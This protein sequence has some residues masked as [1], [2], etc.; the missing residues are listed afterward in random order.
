VLP[1]SRRKRLARDLRIALLLSVAAPTPAIASEDG[2]DTIVVTARRQDER[3]VDVPLAISVIDTQ[4]LGAGEVDSLQTLAARVPGLN[5]E[6][7]W[8]G[9]NSFP[10]L[11]GQN[12]PSV[13]GDNVGM[14]VDGVYQG[15]RD[16]IDVE[17]LD[18]E[19]IEVI[20]GPQSALF[21]R[22]SFAGL[23][24]Y[25]PARPTEHLLVSGSADLGSDRL[26]GLNA[27]ASGPI[28]ARFKAR[29][30]VSWKQASGTF[31]DT[32]PPDQNLGGSRRF[33]LVGSIATRE[34][35]GPLSLRLSGRYGDVRSDQPAFFTLDHRQFNCGGRD[36]ASGVWSYFC[37]E[38]PVESPSALSPDVP[39]SRTRTGQLALHLSLDLGGAELRSLSS[40][41]HADSDAFRDFDGGAP[42]DTYGVCLQGVNC[43]GVG[44]LSIPVVR[45]QMVNIV[46]RRSL[47]SRE[48]SQELRL[49][50]APGRRFGWQLGAALS[51]SRLRTVSAYG[52]ER[53][54]LEGAEHL[55]SLVLSNPQ[56]V[57]A[58]A[59]INNALTVDPAAAQTVQN[60]FIS[61][62][63]IIALFATGDYR[64][65]DT[66]RLRGEARTSWERAGID[67]RRSNFQPSFGSSLGS[68]NF[69][70]ITPRF[71]LD[72]RPA[73]G[74]LLYASYAR[75]SR[76]GG[77]NTTL[78]LAP[79]ERTFAPETNWT[80]E[81]GVHYSGTGL[82]RGAQLTLYDIDWRNTQ[83]LGFSTTPG[84][85]ALITRN[86]R[87]IRTQGAEVSVRIAPARWLEFDMA[88]SYTDPR[89]KP[90]SEDPG[91]GAFCGLSA[92]SQTS[93]FC[94]IRPSTISPGQLVPDISGKLVL[95][96]AQ[97][98]WV[99]GV[100]FAPQAQMLR[101]AKLRIGLNYLDDVYERA[102]NGLYYGERTLLD[103]RLTLP[104]GMFSLD[105]WGTNLTGERYIRA[106]AGRQPQFYNGLPRPTDL[107]LGEGRRV[108]LTLRFE[109]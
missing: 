46:Q 102:V 53:G 34:G 30:A 107:I 58:P 82:V 18:L 84:V 78:G 39:E 10:I 41:Y 106:A 8:G 13:A 88:G 52:G 57:G 54:S 77:I 31:G 70:D 19:R 48:L 90:G 100:T 15:N 14:F 93:S 109:D 96:A 1:S 16:A 81:I 83:I 24:H 9:A 21:G 49:L 65:T 17:P 47:S 32:E 95:R 63:R 35:S 42:G 7:I 108:G 75:G 22:S 80:T 67:S 4:S 26:F 74:W 23:I 43:T 6:A 104:L 92:S 64:L 94:T 79:E 61:R 51:W 56:R 40:V 44:S 38:A 66:L 71:S 76:S 20:H 69:Y 59:A 11:R 60:D 103:A 68:R 91:S 28:D 85:T 27:I 36:P 72:W 97:L 73:G 25:V 87:G 37:G 50:G 5:F 33:A 105:L 89:F 3:L 55:S 101:G 98:S 45:L 12:Q 2:D 62:R 99:G 29:F 86:T